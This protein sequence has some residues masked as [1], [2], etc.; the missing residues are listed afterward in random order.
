MTLKYN[1]ILIRFGE[2]STKRKNKMLFVRKL[3]KNIKNIVGLHCE[4]QFDRIFLKYS[5]KNI[6]GLKKIFGISSFSPV[7]K[8]ETN[9]KNIKESIKNLIKEIKTDNF[10]VTVKR[11]WKEFP[12]TSMEYAKELGGFILRN[13]DWKVDIKNGLK[14]EVEIRKEYTYIFAKRY[15]GLGG[16]PTGINGKVL[17]LISGGIDSPIAALDMMKRGIHV[18]FLNFITPP[19][20][21]FKTVEKIDKIINKLIE[22]QGSAKLFRS[23]YTDL[24]NYEGLTNFQSYKIILM[25]RS[26]YR[27]ASKLA[28]K[29]N[30]LGISNGENIGQVASQ[31]LESMLVIQSQSE[32]PIYRPILTAD[33]QE[34]I[35]RSIKFGLYEI[36]IQ[37]ANETCEM[38]APDN[39]IIKP[40]LKVAKK[41]EDELELFPKLEK[42]NLE[43]KIEIIEYDIF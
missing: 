30:Y 39:P 13:T 23:N 22:Y 4:V 2:L 24:M 37:K 43:N 21:D 28:I 29:Y 7:I 11:H 17:H 31:T 26:F 14:I 35:N 40:K 32:L 27:I 36:S 8:V 6:E 15:K 33:K 16:Y 9:E 5:E 3:A 12:K 19:M 41:L 10:R 42:E 20:T 18:D 38:F 1:E 34:T 25:R